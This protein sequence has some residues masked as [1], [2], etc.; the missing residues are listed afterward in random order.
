[1][2]FEI[3]KTRPFYVMGIVNATPDSF[4]D[5]GNFVALDKGF[6]QAIKLIDDGADIID[7]GGES[8]RPGAESVSVEEEI[9]RVVPL[10]EKIH[11]ESDVVVSI[12]TVKAKVAEAAIA[13]GATIVNDISG[14]RYDANMAHLV[15]R[16]G[17]SVVVMHSR[18]TPKD[19]QDDPF[20]QDV[21]VE[22]IRELLSSVKLFEVEGV[23]ESKIILDPGIGFAKRFEDNL[24]LLNSTSAI[25]KTGH[26][27]LIG[28]SRKSFIGQITGSDPDG[29][30]AGSLASIA[31]AFDQGARLFRV[32][33]VKETVDFLKVMSEIKG[34]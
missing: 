6:K 7:V 24:K 1:M 17:S 5:G 19:M 18:K 32:H 12:D 26:E 20:Y 11:A 33:D 16:S 25:L 34:S 10:I 31:T 13:A 27:V 4:Y 21:V 8:S 2:A 9:D 14:G 3:D 22:V 28:T 23:S 29:R 30:L 15:A